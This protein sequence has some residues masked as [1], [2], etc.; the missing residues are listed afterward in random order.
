MSEQTYD[1]KLVGLDFNHAKGETHDAVHQAKQH[2][3]DLIDLGLI[4][5]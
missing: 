2:C 4:T 5:N 1:Q 3:A